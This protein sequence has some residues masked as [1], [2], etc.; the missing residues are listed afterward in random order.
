MKF[1]NFHMQR[2]AYFTIENLEH[3]WNGAGAEIL[4]R[5]GAYTISIAQRSTQQFNTV[6]NCT[7]GLNRYE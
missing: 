1:K 2:Y 3:E 7:G 6:C 5:G 4:S